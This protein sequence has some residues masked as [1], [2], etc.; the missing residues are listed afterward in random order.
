MRSLARVP[1]GRPIT[2]SRAVG[3]MTSEH[4][5]FRKDFLSALDLERKLERVAPEVDGIDLVLR[6]G[7][8]VHEFLDATNSP[9]LAQFL[10]DRIPTLGKIRLHTVAGAPQRC[11][12]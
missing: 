8:E 9:Q 11:I 12:H 3:R 1:R 6:Q 5:V 10:S 4:S 2:P 7:E